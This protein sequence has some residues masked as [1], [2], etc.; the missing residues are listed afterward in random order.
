[1]NEMLLFIAF[2]LFVLVLLAVL[3]WPRR[4][5]QM[6]AAERG[7]LLKLAPEDLAPRHAK[8]FPLVRRALDG[9]DLAELGTR[10][11]RAMRGK[12]RAERR[13]VARRY[14]EGLRED[15]VRLERFGR[16]VAALSPKVESRQ[17]AERLRLGVRFRLVYELLSLR[18]AIGQ[19]PV[20]QFERL[21][22][23][24]GS[25]ATRLEASMA[26]L[27]EPGTSQASANLGA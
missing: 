14:L 26:S 12:L 15:F 19:M 17:E 2:G 6:D 23:L 16:M 24:V 5:G 1:M 9:S 18:L 7:E 25:L 3:L 10:V 4:G 22:Q 27:I 8:Y 20:P 21:T 13:R 11:P